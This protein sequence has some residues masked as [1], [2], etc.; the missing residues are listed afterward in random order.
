M[1]IIPGP[2]YSCLRRVTK[3]WQKKQS[4]AGK[5]QLL[6]VVK[7]YIHLLQWIYRVAG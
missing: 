5:F 7:I 3:S 1:V 2:G 4:S 6:T